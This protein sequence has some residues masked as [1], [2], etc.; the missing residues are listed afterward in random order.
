MELFFDL[1]FVANLS[2]LTSNNPVNDVR[3]L[4]QYI[5]WFSIIWTTWFQVALFDVRFG[6]DSIVSRVLKFIQFCVMTSLAAESLGFSP[7]L[8]KR[9]ESDIMSSFFAIDLT[10]LISR[11][12]LAI[13]YLITL[14]FLWKKKQKNVIM[15]LAIC[16]LTFSISVIVYASLLTTFTPSGFSAYSYRAWYV[17]LAYEVV[18]MVA[19]PFFWDVL[20]FQK[21]HIVKRMGSLTLIVLGE[22]ILNVLKQISYILQ[23]R[24]WDGI[25]FGEALT[26]VLT[27]FL[28]WALHF[29]KGADEPLEGVRQ[30]LFA[31]L[32]YPFHL[33]L[34]LALEGERF[35]LLAEDVFHQAKKI[36]NYINAYIIL[37]G[38]PDV[39]AAS[40]NATARA[41]LDKMFQG[42]YQNTIINVDI[43]TITSAISANNKSII[44]NALD[45]L[46]STIYILLLEAN[47]INNGDLASI[48]INGSDLDGAAVELGDVTTVAYSSLF[49]VAFVY[50]LVTAGIVL[51]SFGVFRLLILRHVDVFDWICVGVRI[52]TGVAICL[53]SLMILQPSGTLIYG[54]AGSGMMLPTSLFALLLIAI[55]DTLLDRYGMRWAKERIVE[56]P[57]YLPTEPKHLEE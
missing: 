48:D 38:T 51:I 52:V 39:Q 43:N 19:I 23:S 34:A 10:L 22:G 37:D 50:S 4:T 7:R 30:E 56:K 35:W 41:L 36:L 14:W 53:L 42:N 16:I 27:I 49:G 18:A 40:F 13:D 21:T 1:F 54:Y 32:H 5:G 17:I 12:S 6:V 28:I 26:C 45:S 9:Q 3:D 57:E 24:G 31:L 8:F 29:K 2:N 25:V 55:T 20:S 47:N 33:A 46:T 44:D 11:A 15:P